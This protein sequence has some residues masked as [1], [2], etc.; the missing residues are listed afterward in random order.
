M[1][2]PIS[3]STGVRSSA[4]NILTAPSKH[5]CSRSLLSMSPQSPTRAPSLVVVES[6]VAAAIASSSPSKSESWVSLMCRGS[7]L[8]F[9][10]RIRVSSRPGGLGGRTLAAN[11]GKINELVDCQSLT[12]LVRWTITYP[13]DYTS[14]HSHHHHHHHHHDHHRQQHHDCYH[15]GPTPHSRHFPQYLS[16]A[17][18]LFSKAWAELKPEKVRPHRAPGS[19][20]ACSFAAPA[21][22]PLH[23]YSQAQSL[24][25]PH[26]SH[27]FLHL[28]LPPEDHQRSSH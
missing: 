8:S 23:R 22:P 17:L 28:W 26:D 12:M 19:Q 13:G 9:P 10:F 2:G 18:G 21:L 6:R 16:P 24:T 15:L 25:R 3:P 7:V 27:R 11:C 14:H 4:P 5:W 20:G 1:R